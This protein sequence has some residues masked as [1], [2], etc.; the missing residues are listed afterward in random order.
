[1]GHDAPDNCKKYSDIFAAVIS[2]WNLFCTPFIDGIFEFLFFKYVGKRQKQPPEAC[3]FIK[4]E[5]LAQ[6]FSRKFR[7]ISRKTFFTEHL[8]TMAS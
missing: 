2:F 3:N 1:M 7:E 5:T 6:V 4:K 8:S